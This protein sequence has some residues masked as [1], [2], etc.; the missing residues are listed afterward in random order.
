MN[1]QESI[2]LQK[3]EQ[4]DQKYYAILAGKLERME[5]EANNGSGAQH[6]KYIIKSLRGGKISEAKTDCFNQSDKFGSIP[7]IKKIIKL[8]LF[9]KN[10][11]HPWSLFEK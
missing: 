2:N 4:R 11:K 3:Q 8:E 5:S 6:I 9:E 10:E 7:E 1:N